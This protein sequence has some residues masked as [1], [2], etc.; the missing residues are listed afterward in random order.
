[1]VTPVAAVAAHRSAAAVSGDSVDSLGEVEDF[2]VEAVV[3]VAVDN[4]HL[5]V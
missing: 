4:D 1:V 2:R 5:R 3:A